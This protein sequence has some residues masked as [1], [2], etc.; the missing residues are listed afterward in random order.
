MTRSPE[1]PLPAPI[2]EYLA[3]TRFSLEVSIEEPA[4]TSIR[5]LLY[6][7][8]FAFV[9]KQAAQ[10]GIDA[11]ASAIYTDMMRSE[12]ITLNGKSY[13]VHDQYFGQVINMMNR[14]FLYGASRATKFT[15]FHKVASHILSRYG[16]YEEAIFAAN[17]YRTQRR[18]MNHQGVQGDQFVHGIYTS[19]QEHFVVMHELAH[20]AYRNDQA[21]LESSRAAVS[22]WL[23]SYAEKTRSGAVPENQAHITRGLSEGEKREFLSRQDDFEQSLAVQAQICSAIQ[24]RPDL[25]EEFCCDEWAISRMVEAID[26][27]EW[28]TGALLAE[29]DAIVH[30]ISA[31]LLGL[32]NLRTLQLMEA[33]CASAQLDFE[34]RDEPLDAAESIFHVFHSA[35]LHRA[36][37]LCYLWLAPQNDVTDIHPRIAALMDMNRPGFRGGP[38]G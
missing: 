26:A 13:I 15:Y 8:M 38:L 12:A 14:L 27:G 21:A 4:K 19:M 29:E 1:S 37:E 18:L 10:H 35:R 32:L 17:T 25:L 24:A 36:K 22:E 31:L 20:V 7:P 30:K 11:P 9:A 34:L 3:S 2:Q 16:F 33:T 6:E 23:H 5:E 28:K